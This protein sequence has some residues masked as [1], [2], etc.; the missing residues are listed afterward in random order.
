VISDERERAGAAS[1]GGTSGPTQGPPSGSARERGVG[2]G[3]GGTVGGDGHG[4][5]GSALDD[6]RAYVSVL[7]EEIAERG[8]LAL[9]RTQLKLWK[10]VFGAVVIS[11]VALALV[12]ASAAGSWMLVRGV[13]DGLA[14]V[15]PGWVADL[16]TGFLVLGCIALG[17]WVLR[18]RLYRRVLIGLRPP[19]ADA[20]VAPRGVERPASQEAAR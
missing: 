19:D 20:Q 9:A 6:A 16:G 4:E 2:G 14:R 12:A 13:R 1:P 11:V 3:G 5:L 10:G 17:L 15:L 8:R 18:T 7:L